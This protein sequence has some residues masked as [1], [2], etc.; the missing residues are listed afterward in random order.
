MVLEHVTVLVSD[1]F[2]QLL[3]SLVN[4]LNDVA[5]LE[6]DHVVV[7]RAVGQL[8]NRRSAFEFMPANKTSLLELRQN[9]VD[10]G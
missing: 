10:R 9:T 3:N 1:V 5:C 6:T 7:M 8:E 2:L 4:E